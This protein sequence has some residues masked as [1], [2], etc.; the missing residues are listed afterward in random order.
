MLPDRT[1]PSKLLLFGEYSVV[2]GSEAI[3]VPWPK[4]RGR[5]EAGEQAPPL[6]EFIDWLE[7]QDAYDMAAFRKA[8]ANGWCY[9]SDIPIG[10]GV[11]S[12]GAL[13]AAVYDAFRKEKQKDPA[14]IR[15]SL[16]ALEAFFHGSSSGTDPLISYLNAGVHLKGMDGFEVLEVLPEISNETEL[17]LL[18]TGIS[19]STAPLVRQ[20]LEMC[21]DPA[22]KLRIEN[23]LNP[24]VAEAI[25]AYLQEDAEDLRESWVRISQLQWE[26]FQPMIPE[27]FKKLWEEGLHS[28]DY[29]LKLCGAGGGGYFLSLGGGSFRLFR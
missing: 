28:G 14:D 29:Y 1:Y 10:Y 3:A 4:F 27:D 8:I 12:S 2:L 6:D 16:A 21:E 13:T 18:D 19:R 22:Y 23:D 24:L 25:R 26:L 11:G 15:K 17:Y 9:K 20:F 7:S 5:W